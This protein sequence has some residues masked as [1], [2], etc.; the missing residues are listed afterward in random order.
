M[1]INNYE[2]Q[3]YKE[4]GGEVELE[5]DGA[6]VK[7]ELPKKTTD[8]WVV[9]LAE[10]LEVDRS[11]FMM[12]EWNKTFGRKFKVK[13]FD[14]LSKIC[15]TNTDLV[16]W[17]SLTSLRYSR[18]TQ[19]PLHLKGEVDPDE[20]KT[21]SEVISEINKINSVKQ[22]EINEVT[23]ELSAKRKKIEENA[24]IAINKLKADNVIVKILTITTQDL[25]ISIL[26]QID[27]FN[28]KENPDV[29]KDL[30]AREM[31]INYKKAL[32]KLVKDKPDIDIDDVIS[33]G[34]TK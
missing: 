7:V 1:S 3:T 18:L 24:K 17:W 14:Q 29:M 20:Y 22:A 28:P 12:S 31:I 27:N 21:I 30:F 15:S 26:L 34:R 16:E 32:I 9:V 25:P 8:D 2:N 6:K 19:V 4:L 33:K 10:S 5:F 23:R 11:G 13:D